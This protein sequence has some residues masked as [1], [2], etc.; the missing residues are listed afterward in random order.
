MCVEDGVI[1]AEAT[2]DRWWCSVVEVIFSAL[3]HCE[4]VRG[5]ELTELR[6]RFMSAPWGGKVWFFSLCVLANELLIGIV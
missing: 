3:N 1:P 5:T 4:I 2:P 6:H